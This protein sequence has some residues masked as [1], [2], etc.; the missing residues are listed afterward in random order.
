MNTPETIVVLRNLGNTK[1]AEIRDDQVRD[2]FALTCVDYKLGNI[3]NPEPIIREYLNGMP[4]DTISAIVSKQPDAN[5]KVLGDL[6]KPDA[7]KQPI[8]VATVLRDYNALDEN[9]RGVIRAQMQDQAPDK[10]DG[11][12]DLNKASVAYSSLSEQDKSLF[13]D[14]FQLMPMSLHDSKLNIIK[15]DYDNIIQTK[16]QKIMM[17]QADDKTQADAIASRDLI[18]ADLRNKLASKS[19]SLP[20]I[21]PS[22]SQTTDA[23]VKPAIPQN[24]NSVTPIP[25]SS[26]INTEP[27]VQPSKEVVPQGQTINPN[28]NPVTPQVAPSQTTPSMVIDQRKNDLE[29]LYNDKRKEVR[30]FLWGYS[31]SVMI[32]SLIHANPT[33]ASLRPSDFDTYLLQRNPH[34]LPSDR[35]VRAKFGMNMYVSGTKEKH[36]LDL[37]VLVFKQTSYDAV[38]YKENAKNFKTDQDRIRKSIIEGV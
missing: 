28:N 14:M 9:S 6:L 2:I 17:L 22:P 29:R 23:P 1:T 27:S 25:P 3:P 7:L 32:A 38:N 31:Y 4:L 34:V 24:P 13:R 19:N 11:D 33:F 26:G 36:M 12:T 5:K 18:I 37:G 15:T 10:S 8:T 30:S 35:N 21:P 16:D 20:V